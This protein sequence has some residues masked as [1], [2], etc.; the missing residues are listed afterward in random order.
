MFNTCGCGNGCNDLFIIILLLLVCN[1]G[2]GTSNANNGGCG[3]CGDCS[4]FFIIILLLLFCG[5]GSTWGNS[6][7]CGGNVRTSG[8]GCN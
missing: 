3:G 4:E 8:C 5:N 6:C 7:G 1:G 2:F